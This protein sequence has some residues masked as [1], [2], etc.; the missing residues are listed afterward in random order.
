[1]KITNYYLK[2]KCI[3]CPSSINKKNSKNK[4]VKLKKTFNRKFKNPQN[5]KKENSILFAKIKNKDFM[6]H[7]TLN[8]QNNSKIDCNNILDKAIIN[9]LNNN[10]NDINKNEISVD[11]SSVTSETNQRY[12]IS[13]R[14][15]M[16]DNLRQIPNKKLI[17]DNNLY[18]STICIPINLN[19]N[20]IK[21][22]TI[23]Q[24]DKLNN[25]K[26]NYLAKLRQKSNSK[27][28]K[29]IRDIDK[30]KNINHFPPHS[31]NLSTLFDTRKYINLFKNIFPA[32]DCR[33]SSLS[34]NKK[35]NDEK[36]KNRKRNYSSSV[37]KTFKK[38]QL[39]NFKKFCES[40]VKLHKHFISNIN[41]SNSNF[42]G[43]KKL[44][45]QM[46]S[47]NF[48]N[49]ISIT[50]CNDKKLSTNNSIN[51]FLYKIKFRT[52]KT[53][54]KFKKSIDDNSSIDKKNYKLGLKRRIK[55]KNSLFNTGINNIF[56]KEDRLNNTLI[57]KPT[58]KNKNVF[59]EKK[60]NCFF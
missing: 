43:F 37:N 58:K 44:V 17:E 24:I 19:E 10:H 4:N 29:N 11:T 33:T 32:I 5:D 14:K 21:K 50:D 53:I 6:N 7:K 16:I 15:Q 26:K 38:N 22:Q 42:L 30:N 59:K 8:T 51:P 35:I 1:M 12:T 52:S 48:N 13:Y 54:A 55:E 49:K 39:N 9:I 47:N 25:I 23:T 41:Y 3:T 40:N 60:S 20:N 36:I 56:L 45:F 27:E 2:M 34:K 46:K 57:N 28:K 31:K 18:E